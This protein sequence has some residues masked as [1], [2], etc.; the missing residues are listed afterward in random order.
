M[1]I[2][3]KKIAHSELETII[4][5]RLRIPTKKITRSELSVIK[6]GATRTAIES[7]SEETGSIIS[8]QLLAVIAPLRNE[9]SSLPRNQ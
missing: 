3:A 9:Q 7:E 8:F 5:R 4:Y 2:P 6:S 1:R